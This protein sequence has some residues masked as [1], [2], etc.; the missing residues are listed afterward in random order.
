MNTD[1]S[2]FISL[3]KDVRRKRTRFTEQD[4]QEY[5][6][7]DIKPT[8]IFYTTAGDAAGRKTVV[9]TRLMLHQRYTNKVDIWGVGVVV[10]ELCTLRERPINSQL[11]QGP[12]VLSDAEQEI[13]RIKRFGVVATAAARPRSR[14][15]GPEQ[16]R[17][18]AAA[19]EKEAL[20]RQLAA[21]DDEVK[22]LRQEIERMRLAQRQP[23]A[24]ARPALNELPNNQRA[25]AA[26]K[27]TF[28]S[29]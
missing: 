17:A 26:A 9:G 8:N 25:A 11:L 7:R 13:Q 18:A 20:R 4:V 1:H 21:R 28:H 29:A 15:G 12:Q 16:G 23:A 19:A 14:S 22:L 10:L 5:I 27:H 2:S 3:P 24:A 6:H